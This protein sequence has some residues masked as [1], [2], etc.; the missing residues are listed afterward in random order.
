MEWKQSKYR[1]PRPPADIQSQRTTRN[2]KR[3]LKTAAFHPFCLVTSSEWKPRWCDCDEG[4]LQTVRAQYHLTGMWLICN[5][6]T[7]TANKLF[8]IT[9][10]W[11]VSAHRQTESGLALYRLITRTHIT[12]LCGSTKQLCAPSLDGLKLSCCAVGL[13]NHS[14]DPHPKTQNKP[15]ILA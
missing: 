6:K 7:I 13:Q 8:P 3:N 10:S 4:T 2:T 5:M 1:Q 12:K 9:W 11:P 15:P 14:S